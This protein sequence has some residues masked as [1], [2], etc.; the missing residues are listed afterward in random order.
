MSLHDKKKFLFNSN[1]SGLPV[2]SVDSKIIPKTNGLQ[3][4]RTSISNETKAAKILEASKHVEKG[5]KFIQ[6]N[7][8]KSVWKFILF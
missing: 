7:V 2:T 3:S 6:I 8:L 5:E 1:A 4:Q